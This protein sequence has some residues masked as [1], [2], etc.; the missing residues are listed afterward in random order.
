[1]H[2][3]LAVWIITIAA[4]VVIAIVDLLIVGRRRGPIAPATATKWIC[5]YVALALAFSLFL[6]LMYGRS[7]NNEFLASYLTEYSLSADNLF[8]F[9]ILI[10]RFKVPEI[11]VDRV[12]Y[13]GILISLLLRA[14]FIAAG[15]A[16]ISAF[17]WVF[18]LFGAF[19]L[20]TAV[21]LALAPDSD[22]EVK[23]E[24]ATVTLLRRVLRTTNEYDGRR[25]ITTSDGRRVFTPAVLVIGAISVAN[26]V[27]ALDSIPAV[28]GITK[29]TYLVLTANAFALMGLRQLYF[30]IGDLLKRMIYLGIGLSVLLAFIGIKLIFEALH[31]SGISHVGPIA[32]PVISASF[33]LV[34]VLSV[35]AVTAVASYLGRPRSI[36]P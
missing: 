19:L 9:M 24:S 35:L 7:A 3:S 12:L 18:Y 27:F 2:I 16:A 13:L 23:E 6:L 8:V 21:R 5:W 4:L 17:N 31:G 10:A 1:V 29:N 36:G 30:L 25:F 33:S 15:A 28:F 14:A 34:I 22:V 26:L 11:A 20:Y 32:V